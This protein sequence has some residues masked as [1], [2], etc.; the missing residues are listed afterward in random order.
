MSVPRLAACGLVSG[1]SVVPAALLLRVLA[2]A[3]ADD[4]AH[5]ELLP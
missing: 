1:P 2:V 4:P 3:G 5:V